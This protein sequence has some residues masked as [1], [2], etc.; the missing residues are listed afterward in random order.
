[1]IH[2]HRTI[3]TWIKREPLLK[4]QE[5]DFLKNHAQY[6]SDP[7]KTVAH[8]LQHDLTYRALDIGCGDCQSTCDLHNWLTHHTAH[9]KFQIIA[10]EPH[11]PGI[12]K[13][14]RKATELTLKE[15]IFFHGDILDLLDTLP[16]ESLF[17]SI[18]I[19]FSDP[20]QKTRHHKRRLIQ[21]D[22]LKNL[23]HVL[24]E[25]GLIHIAT[26][27]A[28]YAQDIAEKCLSLDMEYTLSRTYPTD[29]FHRIPTK[30]ERRAIEQ[31]RSIAEFFLTKK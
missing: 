20:W 31:G 19:Y 12:L 25:K 22:F 10:A 7:K 30:Y 3:K 29:I 21:V 27:W 11:T 17:D 28:P 24:K 16:R 5:S 8:L 14:L 2:P 26:D 15:I 9:K 1:M 6:L 23:R 18:H 4:Q 13:G